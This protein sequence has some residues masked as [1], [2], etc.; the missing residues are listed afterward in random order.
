MLRRAPILLACVVLAGGLAGCTAPPEEAAADAQPADV[1]EIPGTAAHKLTL[2]TLAVE[3]LSLKTQPVAAAAGGPN[4][5]AVP[6]PSL[7]YDP[8]GKSW[9]YT[10]PVY[11]TYVRASVLVDHVDGD[12]AI[13]RVGPPVGTPIVVV[14]AQELLGTEYGVGE[15]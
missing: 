4:R 15:E 1:V 11:L 5:L 3:R 10:N 9:V 6:V 14:G 12:T 8:E 2:T 13:L 7:V